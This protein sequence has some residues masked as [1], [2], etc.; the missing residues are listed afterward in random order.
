M[1][2]LEQE[3]LCFFKA[4]SLIRNTCAPG[5]KDHFGFM[6]SIYFLTNKEDHLAQYVSEISPSE[7]LH[8]CEK[9][10]Q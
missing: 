7:T 8:V 5:T 6:I 3:L 2:L 9:G 1:S 10:S 4:D